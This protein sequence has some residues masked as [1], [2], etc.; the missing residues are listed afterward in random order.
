MIARPVEQ[1][2]ITAD[3]YRCA[4][5]SHRQLEYTGVSECTGGDTVCLEHGGS[6]VRRPVE[7]DRRFGDENASDWGYEL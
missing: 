7:G 6:E 3:R 4:N 2:E 5:T 1:V